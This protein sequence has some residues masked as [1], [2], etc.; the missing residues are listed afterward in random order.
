MKQATHAP[1][2]TLPRATIGRPGNPAARGR[3]RGATIVLHWS[4]V[5]AILVAAASGLAREVV[6]DDGWRVTLLGVHRQAGLFVL[7][8]LGLRLAVRFGAGMADFSR[9][10]PRLVRLAAHGAHATLYATLLA[11]PLLGWATTSAH[12]VG[13]RLFGLVALPSIA[14]KDA[15]LADALSDWHVWAAW[16]LLALVALHVAAACWHHFV[17]RD[18]VLSAMLPIV[19]PRGDDTTPP[20]GDRGRR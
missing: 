8:A 2:L 4:S 20:A 11:L 7:V 15:D 14:R 16:G 19:A 13:L 10:L 1:R 3:H 12:G 18:R 6:E 5:L 9:G 17:R